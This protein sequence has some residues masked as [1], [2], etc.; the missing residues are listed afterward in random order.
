MLEQALS[1]GVTQSTRSAIDVVTGGTLI[2]KIEDEAYDLIKE[3]AL[4]NYQ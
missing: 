2:N 4:N 1:N 3:M